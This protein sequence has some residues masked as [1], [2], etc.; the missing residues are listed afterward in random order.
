MGVS[1]G[2]PEE[3]VCPTLGEKNKSLPSGN[4]SGEVD[5]CGT[6]TEG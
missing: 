3:G 4:L 6:E 1:E 2:V 5:D